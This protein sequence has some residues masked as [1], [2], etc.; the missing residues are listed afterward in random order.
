MGQ[1]SVQVIGI[2]LIK[3]RASAYKYKDVLGIHIRE[4]AVQGIGW[5]ANL[6][7]TIRHWAGPVWDKDNCNPY[8]TRAD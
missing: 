3:D 2:E 4:R 7:Q 8:L 6:G 1:I 5:E